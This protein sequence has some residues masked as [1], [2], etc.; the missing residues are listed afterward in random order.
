MLCP[1][2][3]APK[4]LVATVAEADANRRRDHGSGNDEYVVEVATRLRPLLDELMVATL[5][6]LLVGGQHLFGLPAP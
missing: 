1:S 6:T 3:Q 4:T 5:V 2:N